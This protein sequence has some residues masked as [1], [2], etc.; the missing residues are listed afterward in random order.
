MSSAAY[1]T[2]KGIIM[3]AWLALSAGSGIAGP[4][5]GSVARQWLIDPDAEEHYKRAVGL[6]K[7]RRTQAAEAEFRAAWERAPDQE[8][9]AY[10]LAMHYTHS[11]QFEKALSV[12]R[13]NVARHGPTALGSRLA[14]DLLLQTK[15]DAP[16]DECLPN[17]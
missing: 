11:R 12:I 10:G 16:A 3:A 4:Q 17:A 7:D 13:D 8:R 9:Y 6:A 15:K 1:C 5:T 14:A 2:Q